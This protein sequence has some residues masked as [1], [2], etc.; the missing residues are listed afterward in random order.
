MRTRF[1]LGCLAAVLAVHAADFP[2]TAVGK[3][4]LSGFWNIPYTPNMAKELGDLPYTPAGKAAFDKVGSAY[5]PT[6]FCLYPGVPRIVNSPFPM[7]IVQTPDRVAFL[8]EYMT[9]FRSINTEGRAHSKN[10]EPTFFGES[11]GRWDGDAFV[12]DTIGLNDRTWLDTAGHQHSEALHVIER[13]QMADANHIQLDITVDDPKM[14]TKPWNNHRV[15]ERLKPGEH[16]L[17]YSCDENNLDR[18]RGHLRP[19]SSIVPTAP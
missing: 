8:Y 16:L 10:P 13:Y 12:V 6:G 17:E 1:L 14:Y 15:L 18:D 7:E 11:V 9:T 2:R 19:G 5:D 4:D 3:P